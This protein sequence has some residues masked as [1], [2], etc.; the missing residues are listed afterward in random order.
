MTDEEP[1]RVRHVHEGH[2]WKRQTPLI[3]V[4]TLV[5]LGLGVLAIY[6]H[7]LLPAA[8]IVV[9]GVIPTALLA[10]RLHQTRCVESDA[11]GLLAHGIL[12]SHRFRWEDIASTS[13]H[14]SSSQH[15]DFYTPTLNFKNGRSYKL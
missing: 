14:K 12:R 15:G 2:S 10:V 4:I 6:N 8:L 3:A 13:V 5:F 7:E 1:E 9:I 11:D